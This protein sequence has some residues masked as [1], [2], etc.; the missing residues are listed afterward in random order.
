MKWEHLLELTDVPHENQHLNMYHM[1]GIEARHCQP[2]QQG[3]IAGKNC[4]P[5]PDSLALVFCS[6]IPSLGT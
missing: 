5:M 1:D 2:E 3:Q 4:N 6:L